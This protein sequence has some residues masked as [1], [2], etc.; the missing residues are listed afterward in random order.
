MMTCVADVNRRTYTSPGRRARAEATRARISEAA[1]AMFLARGYAGTTTAAVGKAA[2]VSE[3]SVFAAFG[4]KAELLIAVVS[5]QVARRGDFPLREQPV[6]QKVRASVDKTAAVREFARL[7]RRAHE[8]SWQLLGVV[9]AAAQDD[10]VVAQ[11]AAAAGMR[12]HADCEWFVTDV[13]GVPRRGAVKKVDA[14]WA[15]ISVENYRRLVIER[16]W[17]ASTYERWLASMLRAT[18]L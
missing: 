7:T 18:L 2:G 3:A 13:M 10:P 9:A 8:N 14:M 17:P 6:W 4:S 12:R 1:A 11:A 5:Q 16:H 15:L